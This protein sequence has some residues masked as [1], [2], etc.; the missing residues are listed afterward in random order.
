ME[1][2]DFDPDILK[3]LNQQSPKF[4]WVI[5]SRI[6]TNY[7]QNFTR[8]CYFQKKNS[9]KFLGKGLGPTLCQPSLAFQPEKWNYATERRIFGEGQ[10]GRH[11]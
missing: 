4:V 7:K 11:S 6:F 10:L 3:C 9:N 8:I 2:C 1:K 5:I